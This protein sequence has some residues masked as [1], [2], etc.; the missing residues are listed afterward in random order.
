MKLMA[1]LSLVFVPFIIQAHAYV[2]QA[3]GLK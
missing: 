3:L 2:L 1:I